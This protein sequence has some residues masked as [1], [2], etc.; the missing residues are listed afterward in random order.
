MISNYDTKS[1]VHK[2]PQRTVFPHNHNDYSNE[3]SLHTMITMITSIL[4]EQLLKVSSRGAS[5][6]Q[7]GV[8][9]AA[10]ELRSQMTSEGYCAKY[11]NSIGCPDLS[12]DG[13]RLTNFP[14]FL[15]LARIPSKFLNFNCG[16]LITDFYLAG[17]LSC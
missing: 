15:F 17:G 6:L 14:Y 9:I 3:Q 5:G 10:L 13:M 12:S 7:L 8:S 4:T 2:G 16:F 11:C 1:P